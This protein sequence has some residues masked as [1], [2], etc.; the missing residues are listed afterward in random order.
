MYCMKG[1][2]QISQHFSY[3]CTIMFVCTCMQVNC[4]GDNPRLLFMESCD[5]HHRGKRGLAAGTLMHEALSGHPCL[6]VKY[7]GRTVVYI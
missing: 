2:T 1:Q 5:R 6:H 7:S 4:D 3:Q